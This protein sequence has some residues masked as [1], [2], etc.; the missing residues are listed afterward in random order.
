MLTSKAFEEHHQNIDNEIKSEKKKLKTILPIRPNF[1]H[2]KII[3]FSKR[4]CS[5]PS[6]SIREQWHPTETVT[7][8]LSFNK[9]ECV[10]VRDQLIYGVVHNQV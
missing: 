5:T 6:F 7:S 8:Q 2:F 4:Q 9:S 3:N 1:K 10:Y